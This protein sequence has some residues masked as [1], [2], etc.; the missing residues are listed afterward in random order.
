MEYVYI[1]MY[2]YEP[3]PGMKYVYTIELQMIRT[4]HHRRMTRRRRIPVDLHCQ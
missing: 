3:L 2:L 4:I 1:Y